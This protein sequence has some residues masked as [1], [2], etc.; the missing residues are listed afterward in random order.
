ME[1]E[2]SSQTSVFGKANVSLNESLLTFS[3]LLYKTIV[4]KSEA[5]HENIVISPLSV[6]VAL[7]MVY[8]GSRGNTAQQ[9]KD[10]IIADG[11]LSDELSFHEKVGKVRIV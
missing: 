11:Q 6:Y 7:C 5:K 2:L 9:I 3:S 10:T 1:K 8:S 4:N